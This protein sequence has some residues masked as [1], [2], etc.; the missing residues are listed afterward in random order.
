MQPCLVQFARTCPSRSERSFEPVSQRFLSSPRR[1]RGYT[2]PF[3]GPVGSREE[4]RNSRCEFPESPSPS[5]SFYSCLLL[6][7]SLPSLFPCSRHPL[8]APS[9]FFAS[10]P[11][12]LPLKNRWWMYIC[13]YICVYMCAF[14]GPTAINL[15]GAFRRGLENPIGTSPPSVIRCRRRGSVPS[16]IVELFD[17]TD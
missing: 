15:R 14:N 12:F 3:L 2:A 17:T 11:F 1:W 13:T 9:L 7:F 6:P 16:P 4:R 8:I 10:C 5:L